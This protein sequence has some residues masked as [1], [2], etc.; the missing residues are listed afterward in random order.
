MGVG[1]I[2]PRIGIACIFLLM[3]LL[4]RKFLL[5]TDSCLTIRGNFFLEPKCVEISRT[6]CLVLL[7]Q[8]GGK[9]KT[10]ML[11]F[12]P[13]LFSN[14][15]LIFFFCRLPPNISSGLS[16]LLNS[17]PPSHYFIDSHFSIFLRSVEFKGFSFAGSINKAML[18]FLLF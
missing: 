18:S 13:A 17:F 3:V 4:L 15:L 9:K 14:Q 5:D 10:E 12:L 11:P 7:K 1:Q 6:N 8:P 16:F 2:G